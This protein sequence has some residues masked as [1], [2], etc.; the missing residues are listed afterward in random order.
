MSFEARYE[1]QCPD[2]G[3][4]IHIGDLIVSEALSDGLDMS[5]MRY[6]HVD[7][8]ASYSGETDFDR[9]SKREVCQK[10]WLL[11]PCECEAS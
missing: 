5:S 3:E 4:R 11:K 8:D 2:C 1:S 9:D 6:V 7:C 10:C